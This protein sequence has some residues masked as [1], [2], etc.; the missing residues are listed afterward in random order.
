MAV[1]QAITF[2]KASFAFVLDRYTSIG[3]FLSHFKIHDTK[4]GF[5]HTV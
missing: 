5:C 4:D 2:E 3:L 1:I